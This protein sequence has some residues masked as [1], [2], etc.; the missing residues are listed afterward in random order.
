MIMGTFADRENY[1]EQLCIDHP[2]V[3]HQGPR[4]GGGQRNSFFRINDEEE[5]IAATINNID[6]PCVC[7]L[8]IQPKLTDKDNALSDMRW[9]W[10]NAWAFLDHVEN[11][12]TEDTMPDAVQAAYDSTFTIM[13]DFIRSMKEDWEENDRCGAFEQINFNTFNAVQIGPTVQNEYGWI[14]YFD[15]EQKATRIIG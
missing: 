10:N 12:S 1:L 15:N 4:E 6:H 3:A 7:N 8:S 11:P 13:E 5:L 2:D 14:L 9:V